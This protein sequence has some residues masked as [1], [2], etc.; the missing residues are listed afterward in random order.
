MYNKGVED[1][2]IVIYL[3]PTDD[4]NCYRT[5]TPKVIVYREKMGDILSLYKCDAYLRLY[6]DDLVND[7]TVRRCHNILKIICKKVMEAE[8]MGD[9]E[10]HT[11]FYT[12]K[13]FYKD[14]TFKYNRKFLI[15]KF[16]H[17]PNPRILCYDEE[18]FRDGRKIT[19]KEL[20]TDDQKYKCF[21]DYWKSVPDYESIRKE[22]LKILSKDMVDKLSVTYGR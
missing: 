14:G 17:S 5:K 13:F 3:K 1:D 4:E 20:L 18:K 16:F 15:K 7:K 10:E 2:F 22:L 12:Y 11:D 8:E 9:K 21:L 6:F 19:L